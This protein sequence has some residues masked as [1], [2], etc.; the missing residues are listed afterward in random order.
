M[1]HKLEFTDNGLLF[2][3]LVGKSIDTLG[4][5]VADE[6]TSR[7]DK[8]LRVRR[9]V[10]G[11]VEAE[12]LFAP[13]SRLV[14]R[15]TVT[16]PQEFDADG[17]QLQLQRA[18]EVS[19]ELKAR[20]GDSK[21]TQ[22]NKK[23]NAKRVWSLDGSSVT[24]A[25]TQHS[26]A[27]GW[28]AELGVQSEL[29]L[30]VV[31][32][33]G[34]HAPEPP[35]AVDPADQKLLDAVSIVAKRLGSDAL[36]AR[37]I[38]WARHGEESEFNPL[39]DELRELPSG[40]TTLEPG[41]QFWLGSTALVNQRLFRLRL[42]TSY[43]GDT[44]KA[45]ATAAAKGSLLPGEAAVLSAHFADEAGEL[46]Y[47]TLGESLPM[48]CG[49]VVSMAQTQPELLAKNLASLVNKWSFYVPAK[50]KLLSVLPWSRGELATHKDGAV[51]VTRWHNVVMTI[52]TK[53][54]TKKATFA[55]KTARS[56]DKVDETQDKVIAALVKKGGLSFA[57]GVPQLLDFNTPTDEELDLQ[58]ATQAPQR[59][60]LLRI[61]RHRVPASV[62]FSHFADYV[63][64][65]LMNHGVRIERPEG[66][67]K[68]AADALRQLS[69]AVLPN[70]FELLCQRS[71]GDEFV[72]ELQHYGVTL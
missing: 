71:W 12:V 60:E 53:K 17:V 4:L 45:F 27:G 48:L 36:Q 30:S 16:F 15:T 54:G 40:V 2:G 68:F 65:D 43:G 29:S 13:R 26:N 8:R 50:L 70:H 10:E 23:K 49:V 25:F 44:A 22:S 69:D 47:G 31:D 72:A 7:F 1:S 9:L 61:L 35:L 62:R 6:G 39:I 14:Y 19:S 11:D 46:A 55:F 59:A 58:R 67:P 52:K 5:D 37:L 21:L 66:D 33:L 64:F 56:L 63:L 32:F 24:F 42:E 3:E 51:W 41:P 18:R 34:E 57:P 20:L 28:Y 38:Q